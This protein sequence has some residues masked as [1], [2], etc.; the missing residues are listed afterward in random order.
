MHKGYKLILTYAGKVE[1]KGGAGV[2]KRK[3]DSKTAPE[4]YDL[5]KDPFEQT[6][7]YGELPEVYE[8]LR[9]RLDG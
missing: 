2:T 6:N 7:L 8:D 3:I 4:I 9:A 1:E 5:L